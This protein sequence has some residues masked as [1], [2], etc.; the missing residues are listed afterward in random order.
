VLVPAEPPVWRRRR[1]TGH[2]CA[3]RAVRA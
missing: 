3:G 1:G 2:A